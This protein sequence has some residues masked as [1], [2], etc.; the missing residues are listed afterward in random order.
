MLV[1]DESYQAVDRLAPI[2]W[3]RVEHERMT[4]IIRLF[5]RLAAYLPQSKRAYYVWA[6]VF[7]YRPAQHLSFYQYS[8]PHLRLI[9]FGRWEFGLVLGI[10]NAVV[11]RVSAKKGAQA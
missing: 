7:T 8:P 6:L 11:N 10:I 4:T 9:V 3:R 2:V 5:G 1:L